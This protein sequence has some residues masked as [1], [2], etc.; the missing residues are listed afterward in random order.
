MLYGELIKLGESVSIRDG[1][2]LMQVAEGVDRL[3]SDHLG[4]PSIILRES[5]ALLSFLH[6]NYHHDLGLID[7]SFPFT[8]KK[9]DPPDFL[10]SSST[11]QISVEVVRVIPKNLA[12]L[13]RLV[14]K[15]TGCKSFETDVSLY[16]D[17]KLKSK[18]ELMTYL[19]FPGQKLCKNGVIGY[20]K[21]RAWATLVHKLIL[22][23]CY[24]DYVADILLLDDHYI[25]S[26]DKE[27]IRK[28]LDSFQMQLD[29]APIKPNHQCIISENPNGVLVLF[30]NKTWVGNFYET[31]GIA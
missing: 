21:E 27:N 18:D 6:K 24:K 13:Y 15:T 26:C 30:Q 17:S 31:S 22:S 20:A 11:K 23:K 28:Q 5:M 12:A 7:I 2:T 4:F 25:A 14:N 9:T 19:L 10:L 8:I 3:Y 16:D 1:T 29:F